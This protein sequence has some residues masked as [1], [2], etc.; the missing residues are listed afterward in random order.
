MDLYGLIGRP[1]GHSFSAA[2]FSSKFSNERIE[3]SYSLYPLNDISDVENLVAENVDL[4]GFNVTAPY[5][6]AIIPYLDSL[7]IEASLV[8]AVNT[9]AVRRDNC[10]PRGYY[11]VGYN[12][13]V[14]GFRESLRGIMHGG[15]RRALV[16][17]TGGASK[18]IC[19]ALSQLGIGAL[20]VSRDSHRGDMEYGMLT[21]D[22]VRNSD[23]IVN[24]TPLG[25]WPD[26]EAAPPFPYQF[27]ENWHIC[28]DLVYNPDITQFM[29]N[30]GI[31][32]AMVKNGLEM[33]HIQAESA[34]KIWR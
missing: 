13:D 9:V 3:A 25:T 23:I 24:T 5:K 21:K 26:C 34:W 33:L 16:L 19:F 32:G 22:I 31:R 30:C 10:L 18:A 1:L 14:T 12:T 29:K 11:M 20:R 2:Y 8:G 17:G 7:D 6:E 28:Y 4:R 27:I 15:E